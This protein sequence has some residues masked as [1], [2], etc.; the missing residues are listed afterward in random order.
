MVEGAPGD[1]TMTGD[2]TGDGEKC[3]A[4]GSC[5]VCS[6]SDGDGSLDKPHSGCKG[7]SLTLNPTCNTDGTACQCDTATALICDAATATHCMSDGTTG[8]CMCGDSMKCEGTM[9]SMANDPATCG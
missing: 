7:D 9:C 1:G 4:D 2:C 6:Q 5:S 3:H 8:I